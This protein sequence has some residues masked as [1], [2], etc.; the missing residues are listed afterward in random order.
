MTVRASYDE[1]KTWPVARRLKEEGGSGY[2]DLAVLPG[3]TICCLYES[4]W[5]GP[6]V[7]AR[8]SIEW[9]TQESQ[10]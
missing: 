7:F 4:G 6:I 2:S 9:L 5:W 8:F 1:G 3:G 10:S